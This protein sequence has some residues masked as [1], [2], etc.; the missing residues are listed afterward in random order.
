MTLLQYSVRNIVSTMS[1]AI[2]LKGGPFS[3]VG[4]EI[5][6][7][8][9]AYQLATG[10]YG[11]YKARERSQSLTELLS[12]SGGELVSTSSFNLSMYRKIR[13]HHSMVHGVVVQNHKVQRTELPKASTAIPDHPGT[14]CLRALTAGLLCLY[15]LDVTVEILQDLIPFALIQCHQED[16]AIKFEAALFASLNHWVSAVMAE[17]DSDV[18][19]DYM[20]KEIMLQQSKLTGTPFDEIMNL[21]YSAVN[22]I[23]YVIGVLRWILTPWH[24]RVSQQY[25]TRSLKAWTIALI[26]ESLGFEVQVGKS[27]ASEGNGHGTSLQTSH[28]CKEAPYVF[29]TVDN[30]RDTDPM[31]IRHTPRA[32]DS[33][34]PE[35][36]MIRG[37]PWIAFRHL[38]G[39]SE[40]DPQFLADVWKLSFN[41]A[42]ARFRGISTYNQTVNITITATDL[43]EVADHHKNLLSEFSPLLGSICG[44]SLRHFVPMSSRSPGWGLAE[45]KE[46]MRILRTPSELTNPATPCRANCYVLYAIV[47]GAIYGLCSNACY[48]NGKVLS[49]DSEIAFIPNALYDGAGVRLKRWANIVGISLMMH[50]QTALSD[51]NDLLFEMFLG[52][53]TQSGSLKSP[54]SVKHINQQ[55]PWR[56]RLLL[57]A[58]A[59]G[60]AAISEILVHPSAQA[61]SFLYIHIQRGQILN[62]PLTEDQYIQASSYI[63]PAQNFDLD[64]DPRNDKLYRFD[65]EGPHSTMRAD[66]EPCWEDDPRTVSFVIRLHG[67]PIASLNIFAFLDNITYLQ[68][69]CQC[70]NPVWEVA[71]PVSEQW[72]HVSLYQLQRRTFPGMS[73][74]RADVSYANN[75]ILIDASHSAAATIY[76]ACILKAKQ[77]LVASACL[78]CTYE[79]AM[80]ISQRDNG[81]SV[82]V[83]IPHPKDSSKH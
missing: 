47:C 27:V 64:S 25:P 29:L 80:E 9:T 83:L 28:R 40:I 59:N 60:L 43:D 56:E 53:D 32:L 26:M 63:E 58:Q 72:Q 67:V 14:A 49:E 39:S 5:V 33:P 8:T 4:L 15:A 16:T 3:Q 17:E 81:A 52:K 82:V 2:N 10:V 69:M 18:F 77:L 12:V 45:L 42:K 23:P 65:G 38:R 61:E 71:V 62:L 75:R 13:T 1:I 48:D 78:G 34:R 30:H 79:Q 55:N 50:H 7:L 19:R 41:S 57:G 66:V 74:R 31:P 73:F 20:H 46:Q 51:W 54:S 24:K 36:T 70:S 37:I 35:I 6:S 21:E 68:I 22:E 11:W 76:A 44:P